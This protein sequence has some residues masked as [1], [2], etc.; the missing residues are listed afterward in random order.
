MFHFQ[1][2]AAVLAAAALFFQS[3]AW[4]S[5]PRTQIQD[6]IYN[7]DGTLFNGLLQIQWQAFTAADTSI[8]AARSLNVP[9]ANG[10]LNIFLTPTTNALTPASYSVVYTGGGRNQSAETWAVPPSASPVRIQ[11]VRTSASTPVGQAAAVTAQVPISQVTGLAQELSL[12]PQEGASFAASR[13]AVID[14]SGQIG[15]A[16][17]NLSDCLHVDGTSGPCGSGSASISIADHETPAGVQNGVNRVFTLL[18]PP[19]PASSLLLFRNGLLFNPALNYSLSGNTITVGTNSVPGAADTLDVSYRYGT[20]TTSINFVDAETPGGSVNG[21]NFTFTLANSPNPSSSLR[22]YR[23]GLTMKPGF[24][25]NLSGNTITFLP[26]ST[27]QIA[28]VLLA[29][30]RM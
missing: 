17:G 27:P 23:N 19:S 21:S 16:T 6:T 28:D 20:N 14:A 10:V 24:D 3:G 25:Y 15:G 1:L 8:I 30:Y 7:A 13:T 2:R 11:T 22:L 26:A 9:I 12:R 5:P 29:F 18:N 4:A